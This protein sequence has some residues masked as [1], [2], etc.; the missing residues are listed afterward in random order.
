M[1]EHGYHHAQLDMGFEQVAL[2]WTWYVPVQGVTHGTRWLDV[3]FLSV[4]YG[5]LSNQ[6]DYL[7]SL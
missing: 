6:P 1:L 5:S 3:Q 4:W 7:V 2:T